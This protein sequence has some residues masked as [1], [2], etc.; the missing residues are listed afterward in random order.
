MSET[1][2]GARG[3]IDPSDVLDWQTG[4]NQVLTV[5]GDFIPRSR[6]HFPEVAPYAPSQRQAPESIGNV[7]ISGLDDGQKAQTLPQE[8]VT[9]GPYPEVL[10]ADN[11]SA[12]WAGG[13]LPF[14]F[15]TPP[16]PDGFEVY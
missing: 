6:V 7:A 4:S 12:S 14:V 13:R 11:Q 15:P 3:L 9:G 10:Q 8:A 2:T 5:D 1:R 16:T